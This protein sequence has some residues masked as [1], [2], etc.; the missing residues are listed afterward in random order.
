MAP[1]GSTRMVI[2]P[3]VVGFRIQIQ[4]GVGGFPV[5]SVPQRV[6]VLQYM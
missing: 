1:D 2:S 3:V 4:F 6:P 5:H